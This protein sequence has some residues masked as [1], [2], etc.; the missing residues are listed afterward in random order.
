MTSLGEERLSVQPLCSPSGC[1]GE[2]YRRDDQD[3][4]QREQQNRPKP[5]PTDS[6]IGGLIACRVVAGA[7]RA[8]PSS[9]GLVVFIGDHGL[10]LSRFALN[11]AV[12]RVGDFG[13]SS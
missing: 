12:F 6:D 9:L 5:L 4:H 10:L 7:I 13:I 1:E 3:N 2:T 11:R 8:I